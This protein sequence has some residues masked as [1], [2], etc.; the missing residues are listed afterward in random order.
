MLKP[1]AR[2]LSIETV[3]CHPL[4]MS[5]AT[6]AEFYCAFNDVLQ[7]DCSTAKAWAPLVWLRITH[8]A[9]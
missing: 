8:F 7:V 1:S 6:K 4:M 2:A 5:L 3:L 9:C